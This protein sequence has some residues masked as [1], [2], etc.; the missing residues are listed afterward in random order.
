MAKTPK[1]N[2][3]LSGLEEQLVE[4]ELRA[5]LSEARARNTEAVLRA[6]KARFLNLLMTED[7][8]RDFD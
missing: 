3:V 5:K 1:T 7:N 8:V 4:A 2:S 6:K